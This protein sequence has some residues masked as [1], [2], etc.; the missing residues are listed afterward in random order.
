MTASTRGTFCYEFA[1][2]FGLDILKTL[3]NHSTRM[4]F[5]SIRAAAARCTTEFEA[6]EPS[7]LTS[8]AVRRLAAECRHTSSNPMRGTIFFYFYSLQLT[9]LTFNKS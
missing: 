8:V 9:R 2:Q 3:K 4:L 5:T 7:Q 1:S 6:V